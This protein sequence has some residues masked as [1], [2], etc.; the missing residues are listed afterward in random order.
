METL[1]EATPALSVHSELAERLHEGKVL[2]HLAAEKFTQAAEL[3]DEGEYQYRH[4][5][6]HCHR[7]EAMAR[8]KLEENSHPNL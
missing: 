4:M 7:A 1:E 3:G 6:A 2:A 5:A 8:S